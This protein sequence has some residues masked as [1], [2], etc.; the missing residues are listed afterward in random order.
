MTGEDWMK[1]V[2]SN[3]RW[4]EIANAVAFLASPLSGYAT[5]TVLTI[6]GGR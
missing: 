2:K 4:Y 6:N 5:G 3:G 1:R